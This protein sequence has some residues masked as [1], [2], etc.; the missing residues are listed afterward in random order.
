MLKRLLGSTSL[1]VAL[2]LVLAASGA[3]PIPDAFWWFPYVVSAIGGPVTVAF[4][5]ALQAYG[6]RRKARAL[7]REAAAQRKLTDGD[8]ENDAEAEAELEEARGD[9]AVADVLINVAK[10]KLGQDKDK[11]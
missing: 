8:K 5:V 11:T 2:P 6:E 9:E 4:G 7:A 1:S 3:A 10:K